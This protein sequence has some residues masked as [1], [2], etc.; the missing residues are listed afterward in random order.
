LVH[1]K[2]G[3]VENF[4]VEAS[5]PQSITNIKRSFLAQ[6]QLDVTGSRRDEIDSNSI[7]QQQQQQ[8]QNRYQE[9]SPEVSKE[10][11]YFTTRE[12]SLLGDCQT[13][14]SIHELPKYRALELEQEWK[15]QEKNLYQQVEVKSK[16]DEV[17]HGK[18]YYRIFKTKN[19]DNCRQS[20][21]FQK[22]VGLRGRCDGSKAACTDLY[23]VSDLII[24]T[25]RFI[26]NS[27]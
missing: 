9:E 16:G 11:T 7:Q 13:S 17:C 10:M 21:V 6:I 14:Y 1:L 4:Y 26:I 20:P 2:R 23:T 18:K 5:E 19:L 3:I 24:I 15:E 8:Q 22:I 27:C 25:Q 12:E